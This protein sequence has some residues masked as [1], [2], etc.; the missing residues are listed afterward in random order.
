MRIP[1]WT[2]L[3]FVPTLVLAQAGI[4]QPSGGTR[5]MAITSTQTVEFEGSLQ[6]LRARLQV[7]GTQQAA[8]TDYERSVQAY[9]DLFFAEKPLA[10]SSAEAAPR[11]VELL[12]ERMQS[13]VNAMQ[14]IAR[15]AKTMYAL[16]NVQQQKIADR[17]LMA[18]IPAFGNPP[19]GL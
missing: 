17:Y 4:S 5:V 3:L 8:W 7:T 16:L 2:S 15:A 18:S 14:D 12:T 11:Q 19:P 1:L 6:Q 13:R 10:A 9:S